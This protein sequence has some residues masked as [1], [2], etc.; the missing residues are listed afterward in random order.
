MPVMGANIRRDIFRMLER[1]GTLLGMCVSQSYHSL[2]RRGAGLVEFVSKSLD[3][4]CSPLQ[5]GYHGSTVF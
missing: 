5:T 3:V 2:G 4:C 1:N